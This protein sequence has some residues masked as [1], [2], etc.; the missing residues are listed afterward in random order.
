MKNIV[1][2]IGRIFLG[3]I[4]IF[5]AYDA[6]FYFKA[7]KMAMAYYGLT[8][9]QDLLLTGAI[10]F[11]ILGGTLLLTG[12]RAK[13][14]AL[15]LLCYWIPLTFT[16]HSFWN[17]PVDCQVLYPCYNQS[18]NFRRLQSIFFMKNLAI[19]GGLLMVAA[20]GTGKYSI[21]RLFATARVRGA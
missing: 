15:L 13:L 17:D 16:V 12:Y 14:G 9:R 19:I 5:E 6:L 21:K 4:F 20:N 18:D 2:L 10:A 8:W 7:N 1:D 11:L 3:F